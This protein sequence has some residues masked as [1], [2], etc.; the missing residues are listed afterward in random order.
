M[1]DL[2][3]DVSQL[4]KLSADLRRVSPALQKDFLKGLGLAGDVVASA[5]K[6][7]A[8]FSTRIP[9]TIKVRRRGV[10]VSVVAGGANAPHAGPL[11]NRGNAGSFRHPVFGNYD[12][13]VSQPAHP[14]LEN[15]A[16]EKV[17]EVEQIILGVTNEAFIAGGFSG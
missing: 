3:I 14:F 4:K 6:S 17:G 5:A 9:G 12:V 2:S 16:E 10:R 8:S 15:S 11:D 13:W 7:K 1:T